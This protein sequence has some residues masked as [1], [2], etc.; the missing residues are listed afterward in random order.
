MAKEF[1]KNEFDDATQVKL[2]IFR[3]YIR[4]W[5][6]VFLTN[7]NS[8]QNVESVN[9][10]DFFAGPGADSTGNH[11]SPRIVQDELRGY[12]ETHHELKAEGVKVN[13]HFNDKIERHITQLKQCLAENACPK[14][15]CNTHFS[16]VLFREAFGA[17]LRIM[18][19]PRSANLVIMDQFG[20][21]EVTPEVV[22]ALSAC[23]RTDI[24]FFISSSYIRRF[25]NEPA[26]QACFDLTVEELTSSD[27]KSI[28][29]HI[30][31]YF[32]SELQGRSD[33]H[34]APFSIKKGSNIYGVVFGSRKLLGL[35]KFLKVCWA[36]D[37][38][39]GE[40]NYDI[41]E[42]PI[43]YGQRSFLPEDNV[44]KKEFTFQRELEGLLAG[45]TVSSPID[46]RDLYRFTL[47][48]GFLPSHTRAHLIPLQKQGRLQVN[49]I[50]S[51][52]PPKIGAFYLRDEKKRVIFLSKD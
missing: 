44:P 22:N 32:R 1:H 4:E 51:A 34:L 27:Y 47:E 7:R 6:P 39:T 36:L 18:Q 21:K 42:D 23:P 14:D 26:F 24:L 8:G 49:A 31:K 38:V 10:F 40:A 25:A 30:C 13:L 2:A 33:Y 52:K 46:N 19:R 28:H 9:V 45:S 20:V 3:G 15:S 41:D 11:G 12:C 37:G 43:R 29:R 50:G 16:S 17:G 35:E 48:K 5:L